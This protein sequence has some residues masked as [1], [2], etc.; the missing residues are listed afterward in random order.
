M[1]R[2]Y[3]SLPITWNDILPPCDTWSEGKLWSSCWMLLGYSVWQCQQAKFTQSSQVC[4]HCAMLCSKVYS[5]SSSWVPSSCSICPIN[6]DCLSG[7][8]WDHRKGHTSMESQP[9][10]PC[11]VETQEFVDF[12]Q[13]ESQVLRVTVLTKCLGWQ[14]GDKVWCCLTALNLFADPPRLHTFP[15]SKMKR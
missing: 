13:K 9:W 5:P 15:V 14:E 11:T 1:V 2:T 3:S 12:P 6:L 8:K 10:S 4:G 7:I